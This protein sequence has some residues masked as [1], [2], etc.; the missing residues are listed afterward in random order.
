MARVPSGI[1]LK[2]FRYCLYT[3]CL[4]G[5][6]RKKKNAPAIRSEGTPRAM[7]QNRYAPP[8]LTHHLMESAHR[9]TTTAPAI[10]RLRISCLYI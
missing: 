10:S 8:S 3:G 1:V 6:K 4:W 7:T 9:Y 5:F 2:Y